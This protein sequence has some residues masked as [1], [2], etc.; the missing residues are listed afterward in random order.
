MLH[1]HVE[2]LK[3]N[4][5]HGCHIHHKGDCSGGDGMGA[6]GPANS[7]AKP[8]GTHGAAGLVASYLTT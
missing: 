1:V 4:Q 5:E 3:P 2:G 6:G 8:H 7:T